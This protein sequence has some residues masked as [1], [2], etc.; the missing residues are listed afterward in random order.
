MWMSSGGTSSVVHTDEY[1][2]IICVF[3]GRKTFVMVDPSRY[4]QKV[5]HFY[6][7]ST[8]YLFVSKS[9]GITVFKKVI[10]ILILK[11]FQDNVSLDDATAFISSCSCFIQLFVSAALGTSFS[12]EFHLALS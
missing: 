3:D 5:K 9:A 10:L 1:E 7:Y 2:N 6:L 12:A 4:R 8:L 11:L